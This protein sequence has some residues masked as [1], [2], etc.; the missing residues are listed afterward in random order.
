MNN[1]NLISKSP[2]TFGVT[3]MGVALVSVACN[4]LKNTLTLVK[5]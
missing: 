2:L 1:M 4:N 3:A 5:A